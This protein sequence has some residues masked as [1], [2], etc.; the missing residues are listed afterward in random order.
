MYMIKIKICGIT[1]EREITCLN[2]TGVDYAGFVMGYPK[3]KRNISLERASQ[4]LA[5]LSP[6]IRSVAVMVN[7]DREQL[8]KV[9][10]AGFDLVQIHGNQSDGWL[11]EIPI[12]VL[13]ALQVSEQKDLSKYETNENI[14]GYVFDAQ[15]PGSG[16]AFDWDLLKALPRTE[17]TT[18]L[19][20][21]LNPENIVEALESTNVDGVDASSG[22]E[23]ENGCGKDEDK[24]REF[25][26]LIR[27]WEEGVS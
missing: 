13:K 26:R 18:L 24:I 27:E 7:P 12:P 17:K 21:G 14:R 9:A 16:K 20:G 1:Q 23:R 15:V 11:G 6:D 4:L 10:Q 19:A 25:V 2:E 5:L 8:I 22:V 3:S